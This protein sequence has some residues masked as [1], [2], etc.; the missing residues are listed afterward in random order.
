MKKTIKLI[1]R[2][3]YSDACPI[4]KKKG[5]EKI[6]KGSSESQVEYNMDVHIRQKHKPIKD[7]RCSKKT[8]RGE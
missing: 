6:I 2:D 4:C 8:G 1:E 5:I 3:E 7:K